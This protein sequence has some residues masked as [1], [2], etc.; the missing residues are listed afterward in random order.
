MNNEMLNDDNAP[1][2]GYETLLFEAQFGECPPFNR[3]M[4]NMIIDG[5]V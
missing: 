1:P 3:E 5:E 2:T 4:Y